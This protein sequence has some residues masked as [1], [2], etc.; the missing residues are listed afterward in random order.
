M[1]R[2]V[3]QA[4]PLLPSLEE[5]LRTNHKIVDEPSDDV[6]AA[7]TSSRFGVTNEQI[8]A[9]PSLRAIVHFGVGYETTD[10]PYARS[11]GIVVSNTPDVLTDCVA[12]LAVGGMI[13]V[14]R[15]LTAADR[16][17]RRGDWR[18][19]QFPLAT[20]VTGRRVGILGLGRIGRAIAHR[21]AAFDARLSYHSRHQVPG[22]PYTYH[23]SPAALAE[24]VEV[25]VV[26]T[27]GGPATAGLVS[28]DVLA[29]LGPAGYL[30]NIAR[31]S[32]VD[33]PALVAALTT[34]GIAGAALDVF[35]DEPNVPE[36]LLG[37]DNVVLLPHI[38]SATVETREAMGDLAFRN[39][40]QFLTD[41]TLLTP[42]P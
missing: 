4:C 34:G 27:S 1:T 36:P 18:R 20:K 38:A 6:V 32:V 28:S 31:G 17:V 15:R 37:L 30:V 8:D 35:A 42:V 5:R 41:G 39:L 10:V 19:G 25:L 23:D 24:A 40:H 22:L 2:P 3:W 26:A 33:E 9:L 11:R 13:D 29:A 12:D 16:F 21:L 7:I 14:L